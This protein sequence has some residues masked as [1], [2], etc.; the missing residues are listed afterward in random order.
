MDEEEK[1]GV[2]SAERTVQILRRYFDLND[3]V[4]S[5]NLLIDENKSKVKQVMF[6]QAFGL[7]SRCGFAWRDQHDRVIPQDIAESIKKLC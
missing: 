2:M 6:G 4:Q 7:F 1:N 3:S 5:Q